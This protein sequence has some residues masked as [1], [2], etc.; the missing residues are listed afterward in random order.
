[1]LIKTYPLRTHCVSCWTTYILQDDTRSQQCQVKIA[2][3]VS[4]FLHLSFFSSIIPV[5]LCLHLS[6]LCFLCFQ[7]Y[8][9]SSVRLIALKHFISADCILRVLTFRDLTVQAL[10]ARKRA[11]CVRPFSNFFCVSC[12][13]IRY[14]IRVILLKFVI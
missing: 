7:L 13:V 5:Y 9:M 8:L 12:L 3:S 14:H 2:V 4:T 1:M 6:I 11:S 10:L